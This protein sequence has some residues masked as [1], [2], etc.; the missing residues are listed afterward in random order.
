LSTVQDKKKTDVG[1]VFISNYPP[2]STWQDN[3]QETILSAFAKEGDPEI[4]MGLYLHIPF[5]R[6]RCKFCYFKVYTDKNSKEIQAYLDALRKEAG[7]I[8]DQPAVGNRRLKYFYVGGGTPSYISARHLRALMADL[9]EA[10]PWNEV[11]EATFECEPGTLTEAKLEAIKEVGITRLSLGIEN[12]DDHILEENGRAHIST[13]VYRVKPWIEKVGF[14]QLNIDLISGMVGETWENWKTNIEKVIDYNPDSVTIYQMELPFNTVYSGRILDG[15]TDVPDFADWDVKRAWHSYAM[16]RLS[17]V[18]Y[19]ISSGYTMVKADQ[20]ISFKY[21]DNLWKGSD[22]LA[23]GCSSFGHIN[24]VHYQN[25]TALP[26]YTGEVEAGR[27]PLR[28]AFVTND[29]ERLT[30]EMILQLKLGKLKPAYF[31]EKYGVD[32]LSEF[33]DQYAQHREDG[34]LTYTDEEITLT[35]D[36]LLRVDSLLPAFYEEKYQNTRYT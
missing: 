9:K 4:P 36:G 12:F 22:L 10:M 26:V 18:G 6:K 24:G 34:Y 17:E 1:S 2:F 7:M 32:I 30:R 35:R 14:D 15:E 28:R 11:E 23:L 8:A 25:Q 27:M 5:C 13:E 20:E 19:K 29:R 21:R 33:A 16:D 3:Q 31:K